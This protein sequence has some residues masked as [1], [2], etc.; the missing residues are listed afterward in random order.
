M[1][2][3]QNRFASDVEKNGDR[4]VHNTKLL[5][6]QECSEYEST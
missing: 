6:F 3:V 5:F 1:S 2:K 4:K